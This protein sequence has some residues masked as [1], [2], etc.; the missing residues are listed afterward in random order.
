MRLTRA[1]MLLGLHAFALPCFAQPHAPAAPSDPIH[2]TRNVPLAGEQAPTVD[3]TCA[4]PGPL[5][6]HTEHPHHEILVLVTRGEPEAVRPLAEAFAS[7]YAVL[8]PDL[9]GLDLATARERVERVVD[10][11]EARDLGPCCT[12]NV[13]V[14]AIVFM[15]DAA[16]LGLSILDTMSCHIHPARRIVIVAP[17]ETV[18]HPIE[19]CGQFSDETSLMPIVVNPL[20]DACDETEDVLEEALGTGRVLEIDLGPLCELDATASSVCRCETRARADATRFFAQVVIDALDR[21]SRSEPDSGRARLER[22]RQTGRLDFVEHVPSASARVGFAFNV[23]LGGGAFVR[24]TASGRHAQASGPALSFRPEITFGRGAREEVGFGLYGELG[25]TGLFGA[26]DFF[27]GIG[28]QLVLPTRESRALVPSI[29][30][31][32][33]FSDRGPGITAGLF[34]GHR[35]EGGMEW[36]VGLRFDAR[37]S[38][39]DPHDHAFVLS[40]QGELLAPVA[41]LAM[42]L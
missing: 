20:G 31:H 1:L 18:H 5:C 27:L 4:T 21:T 29:G 14:A 34:F 6:V 42:A 24:D 7:T 3:V 2:H 39:S 41:V 40:F 9:R 12:T 23:T 36:P 38:L 30:M 33:R 25:T 13:G 8:T 22:A 26:Q 16:E 32:D 37:I 10:R 15:A 19:S 11:A 17:R 28:A 35:T